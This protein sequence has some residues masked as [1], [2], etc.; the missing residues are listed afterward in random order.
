MYVCMLLEMSL[1]MIS[2]NDIYYT[3]QN[4]LFI[5]IRSPVVVIVVIVVIIHDYNI[6]LAY[7]AILFLYNV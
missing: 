6:Y 4:I 1:T 3:C 2:A 7:Y 5:I